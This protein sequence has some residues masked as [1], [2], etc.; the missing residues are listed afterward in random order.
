VAKNSAR[1]SVKAKQTSSNHKGHSVNNEILRSLPRK[2]FDAVFAVLEYVDLPVHTILNEAGGAITSCYFVE[3]GL[4]SI[5]SV[6]SQ[7]KSVEVGLTGKEGFVG[8]PLVVGL[9]TSGARGIVQIAATA[10][11]VNAAKMASVLRQCPLLEKKLNRYAQA[12]G[13]Q[14]V[15]V[16][17]CNRLHEVDQRLARWLLMCQDRIGGDFVPLTQ[18]FLGHMLGTRRASVTVAAG[19]LQKAGLINYNRGK[20]RI[21]NRDQL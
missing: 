5:L 16:A 4:V 14:S 20:V 10:F 9:K 13:A 8:L 7:G 1:A 18:E 15:Q 19:M 11:R 21:V 2:E 3:S 6:L 17:A 12:L